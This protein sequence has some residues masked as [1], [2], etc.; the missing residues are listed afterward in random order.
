MKNMLKNL[1]AAESTAEKGELATAEIISAEFARSSIDSSITA[2]DQ[3]RANIVAHIKSPSQSPGILIAC[4]ID[5]VGPGRAKW[6]FNPFTPTEEM[7]RIYG[8]GAADMKGGTA[9]A[10][11]A[12]R[13]L[14]DSGVTLQGDIVFLAAA[15]EETDSC[16]AKRFMKD[17]T[18]RLPKFQG[19]IIPE[20]TNFDVV[21]SH[22]G[23]LWLQITTT[24]KAAHGS[25]P[26]DGI[27]AIT[28]MRAVMNELD[29][30]K[31]QYAPH[32]QLGDCSM[33]L[34]TITAGAEINVVPDKCSIG[35]DIRTL[36]DQSSRQIIDGLTEIFAKLKQK[37]PDFNAEISVIRNI[38][39]METDP[40]C[41]F[42]KDLCRIVGVTETIPVGFTTDGPHFAELN[43]PIVI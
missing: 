14:I 8:R 33:S 40:N 34:N 10:V 15:G 24:G 28:K 30:F 37:D 11:T 22:R 23:I 25:M 9:A 19:I 7:G 35:I 26:Q 36:P 38:E 29:N 16:G 31:I 2:W 18:S 32:E 43:A 6:K 1:I 12:I 13:Q 21:T 39:A 27:N 4:H 5:V 41:T 20:P 3:N 42:V 17:W